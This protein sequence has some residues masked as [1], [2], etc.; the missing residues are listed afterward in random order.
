M[1]GLG[2]NIK[3]KKNTRNINYFIGELINKGRRKSKL[4]TMVHWHCDVCIGD[5]LLKASTF[6][7]KVVWYVD[8]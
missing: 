8:P 2:F 4:K 1:P 5:K 7:I 6:Q 3:L